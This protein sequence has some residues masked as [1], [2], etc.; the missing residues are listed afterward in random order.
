MI[1]VAHTCSA[2]LI[3]IDNIN[4]VCEMGLYT[5]YT[6]EPAGFF[7]RG[8]AKKGSLSVKEGKEPPPPPMVKKAP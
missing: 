1:T 6:W 8:Q 3:A 4:M 5:E 7:V 2:L